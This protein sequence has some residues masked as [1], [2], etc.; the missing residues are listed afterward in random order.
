MKFLGFNITRDKKGKADIKSTV[1]A[2][3]SD[4]A[5]DWQITDDRKTVYEDIKRMVDSDE[6]AAEALDALVSDI[7]PLKNWFEGTIPGVESK[8]EKLKQEIEKI[9][10][11]SQIKQYLRNI[12]YGMLQYGNRHAEYVITKGGQFK[13][14]VEIPQTW[15]VYRNVDKHGQLKDGDPASQKINTCAYDQRTDYG[16]FLA[17]FYP[18][19]IIHWRTPPYDSEGNGKPFLQAARHNWIKMQYVEDALRRARIER[20]YSKL[21][22]FVPVPPNATNEEV[23][24]TINAYIKSVTKKEIVSIADGVLNRSIMNYLMDVETNFYIGTNENTKGD[25]KV[26]D[27]SNPQLQNIVDMEYFLNRLF[28]RLKVPKARLANEAD[29]RAKATMGEINTAYAQTIMGYQTDLLIPTYDMVNRTLF[30]E[31]FI[32]D[33]DDRLEYRLILPSPFVKDD[34]TRA[35]IERIEAIT[36]SIWAKINGLSLDTIRQKGLG[37]DEKESAAEEEKILAQKDLFPTM[38]SPFGGV[39]SAKIKDEQILKELFQLRKVR[40]LMV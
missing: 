20:A 9:L 2:S 15:S 10:Q 39:M 25:I 13:K 6:Y 30:L 24:K 8:D 23:R 22:H 27:P 7:L 14:I 12:A 3:T 21:A 37:M 4:Y 35:E 1:W 5:K 38:P 32:N 36:Y 17:G 34:K 11:K 18:Y 16:S 33:I 19:Q 31:G 40:C 28:A 29:V 26:L